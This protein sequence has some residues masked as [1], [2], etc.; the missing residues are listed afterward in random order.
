VKKYLIFIIGF[1]LLMAGLILKISLC[2]NM[3]YWGNIT[4]ISRIAILFGLGLICMIPISY[5]SE[6]KKFSDSKI[7]WLIFNSKKVVFLILFLGVVF[8]LDWIGQKINYKIR[9]YY[10]SK[11]TETTTGT[12]RGIKSLDL[13]KVGYE[14]FCI[15]DFVI[16]NKLVEQGLML[17][18]AKKDNDYFKRFKTPKISGQNLAVD[19]LKGNRVEIL[20]SKKY[21]SFFRI[22]E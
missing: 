16:D 4:A 3:K 22:N 20:Y 8:G 5:L 21:P 2:H 1:L 7:G 15:V 13:V 10:L 17:K 9:D 12:I 14:K 19:R 11:N 18:Y 6:K